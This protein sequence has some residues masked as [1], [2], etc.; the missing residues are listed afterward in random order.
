[1]LCAPLLY[2]DA[3]RDPAQG[4]AVGLMIVAGVLMMQFGHGGGAAT[5]TA[6]SPCCWW[7]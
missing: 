1:M 4:L 7:R 3:R 6:G 5:A 2:R